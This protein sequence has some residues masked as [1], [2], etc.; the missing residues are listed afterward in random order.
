MGK[1]RYAICSFFVVALFGFLVGFVWGH[2]KPIIATTW[3]KGN[4]KEG[5]DIHGI[6]WQGRYSELR[7]NVT[8]DNDIDL[9][10]FDMAFR[11]GE[12]VSKIKQIDNLPCFVYS[13]GILDIRGTDANGNQTQ[14]AMGATESTYRLFCTKIPKGVG[15]NI[16]A[17]LMSTSSMIENNPANWPKLKEKPE[18]VGFHATY[19]ANKR[20]YV[21]DF[22]KEPIEN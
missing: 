8:N 17:A 9:D 21:L 13:G 12:P 10:D 3:D 15:V 1:F 18:W 7:I 6:D 5:T 11:I 20:P 16:V 4:Y 22:K 19:K 2:T 14:M